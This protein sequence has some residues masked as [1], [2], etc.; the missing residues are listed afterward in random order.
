MNNFL[1]RLKTESE[2]LE[3]RLEK[4]IK[5]NKTRPF[6]ALSIDDQSDLTEQLYCM[7]QLSGILR[8]R[9][10]KAEGYYSGYKQTLDAPGNV[11]CTQT[12][13]SPSNN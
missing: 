1:S 12:L 8:K 5:F 11:G 9:I 6:Y 7:S 13:I 3:L 2:D 4:L 10:A